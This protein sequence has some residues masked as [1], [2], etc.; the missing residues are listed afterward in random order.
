ME[1]DEKIQQLKER[2]DSREDTSPDYLPP[3][4]KELQNYVLTTHAHLESALGIRILVEIA[5]EE[6]KANRGRDRH[7][8]VPTTSRI[9]DML[10]FRDKLRVIRGFQDGI[11]SKELEQVNEKRIEFAHPKGMELRSKYDTRTSAG[12]TA[13]KDLLQYLVDAQDG[14]DEYVRKYWPPT[15][16]E[17]EELQ[18][19]FEF[20][21]FA[22]PE[23]CS[24][25]RRF[26][27]VV[28]PI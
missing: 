4:V 22:E 15:K 24:C 5:R 7:T 3:G 6:G 1:L 20:E 18:G 13:V 9:V 17:L 28:T 19:R 26:K 2:L 10:S 21:Y 8:L 25:I 14:V 11:P 12:K 27:S 16:Q 23:L